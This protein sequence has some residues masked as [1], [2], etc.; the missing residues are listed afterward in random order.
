MPNPK[1]SEENLFL[2]SDTQHL[3]TEFCK[4]DARVYEFTNDFLV[5]IVVLSG[6]VDR[7]DPWESGVFRTWV[8]SFIP[9][10]KKAYECV[11]SPGAMCAQGEGYTAAYW[12]R[13]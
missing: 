4:L 3:E 11:F 2:R 10:G 6:A 13:P 8:R 9:E 5:I 7:D 1:T 12:T